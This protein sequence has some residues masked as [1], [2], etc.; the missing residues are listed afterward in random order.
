MSYDFLTVE[1]DG[2]VAVVTLNR[3]DNLNALSVDLMNEI[4]DVADSFEY[5]V[6]TRAV[7]FAGAGKHFS[8]GADLKDPKRLALNELSLNERRRYTHLGQKMVKKLLDI[9]QI[10]IAAINGVALGGAGVIVS[11]LDFRVGASDCR[12]GYPEIDLGMN[13]SWFGLPLCLRLVGPS[14]AKR[15]VILGQQEDAA[16]LERWGFL[17]EVVPPD[18]LMDAAMNMARAYAKK[19]PIP[20]QMIKRS[21]NAI[22]SGFDQALMHMDTDQFILTTMTK[23]FQ[24]GISSF[25][26]KREPDFKGD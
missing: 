16:T 21:A 10:T 23:D 7:V 14:R 19:P 15:M 17:D 12:V 8:A 4:C 5:D 20:A 9:N 1:R 2:F 24:E 18:Q 3:P 26:E 11:A 22:A 6:E 25:M 13:L